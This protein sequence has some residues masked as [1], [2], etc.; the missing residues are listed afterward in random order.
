[1]SDGSSKPVT[2]QILPRFRKS[3]FAKPQ[4]RNATGPSRNFPKQVPFLS[5]REKVG[6]NDMV[7]NY[8]LEEAKKYKNVIKPGMYRIVT[9][10]TQHRTPQ[11]PQT[12]RNANSRVSTST[13]VNHTTSVSRPQPAGI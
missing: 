1:M 5:N 8:Y 12:S 4:D 13:G 6:S 9:S 3:S 2:A 11:L 10:S 7:H